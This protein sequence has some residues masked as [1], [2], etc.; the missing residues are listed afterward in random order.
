M[1]LIRDGENGLPTDAFVPYETLAVGFGAEA[2]ATK[3]AQV[4]LPQTLLIVLHDERSICELEPQRR[5]W[6]ILE[7][8]SIKREQRKVIMSTHVDVVLSIL[9]E[10]EDEVSIFRVEL[11]TK[12]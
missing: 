4:S 9:N 7:R 5:N 10:L 3:R 12:H 6:F 11:S 2:G 1:R 8:R